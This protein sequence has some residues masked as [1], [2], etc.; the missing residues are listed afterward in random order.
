MTMKKMMMKKKSEEKE[1]EE[2]KMNIR[3]SARMSF[4]I[5]LVVLDFIM[6]I[7]T[8]MIK[9]QP[10][11]NKHN[12]SSWCESGYTPKAKKGREKK[13]EKGKKRILKRKKREK[14]GKEK[15]KEKKKDREKE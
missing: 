5:L 4:K 2:K 6:A 15:R 11:K 10:L 12:N 1:E 14:E 8:D 9:S 3:K 7:I 13:K